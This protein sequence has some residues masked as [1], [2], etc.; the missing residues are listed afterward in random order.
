MERARQEYHE[1]EKLIAHHDDLYYNHDAPEI[2]DQAYDALR[3][4]LKELEASY[5]ALIHDQ[6]VS[7]K[8]GA[9][10]GSTGFQKVT[11]LTPML[12]LDN[13]FQPEDMDDF[14]AK[15]MRFL[16][17]SSKTI[18]CTAEPKIDGL[19]CSLLYEK[20]VLKTA[21]TR[22]DGTMGEDIT[23]NVRIISLV[24]EKL[25]PPY[26]DVME[27]RGEIYM[28][29]QD[30]LDLNGRQQ[31]QGL[32]VFANP[33]NG[34]AGSI[35]QLDPQKTLGRPL[36]FYPYGFGVYPHFVHEHQQ[37][38]DLFRSWGF[39]PNTL[40]RLCDTPQEMMAYYEEFFKKRSTLGFDIDGIV[41]KINA[42]DLQRRLGALART[43]RY[44][45]AYKFP[46]E[47]GETF[48]EDIELSVGRTGVLTPTA[49][50]KPVTLGGVV[51]TR[52]TLHNQE[53]I[54]R[55]DIRV[56]DRVLVQRAGDVI[57][58][59][60][61]VVVRDEDPPRQGPFVFPDTCPQCGS[62]LEK[63]AGQVA[64]HCTGTFVCQAQALQNLRHF[65]SKGALNIEGLGLQNLAFFMEK[66][67]VRYPQDLFTLEK[68]DQDS[69]T[70]LRHQPGWGK[71]SAENLF[72]AIDQAR[73]QPLYRFIYG[74]GILLIGEVTA[75]LL[76]AHYKTFEAWYQ[77]MERLV[78]GDQEVEEELLSL[79]GIGGALIKELIAFFGEV[80]HKEIVLKT[81]EHMV[82]ET[83]KDASEDQ[84]LYGKSVVFTGSLET[85]TR[86]E[87]K[88]QAERLGAKVQSSVSKK[89]DYVVVGAD[90]G[91]KESAARDLGLTIFSEEEWIRHIQSGVS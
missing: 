63:V 77:A 90:A 89:T 68:R 57:P 25:P 24:P 15:A 43:P 84:L 14:L 46:A 78:E 66:G 5:P 55:K 73:R 3:Q 81:R 51:V 10:L 22:G 50:L 75:K 27:I 11:H 26:P 47:Q 85:L 62:P 45:L 91:K 70:P 17:L 6:A 23:A 71:K 48:I 38:F 79:D 80:R 34:A 69:L 72:Q 9:R 44:A 31:S 53:E 12:S 18:P 36:R 74:L 28:T 35:R 4:R 83:Q 7:Q 82:F 41:Y 65:V 16:G 30:F 40:W 19:S 32:K 87:A 56:G 13:G 29:H 49:H 37:V 86:S 61:K 64:V 2:S 39:E 20:G 21:A 42:V 33:R 1:L 76:A 60:L 8:V 54:Q 58:Q 67:W 59:V 88:A 52:A